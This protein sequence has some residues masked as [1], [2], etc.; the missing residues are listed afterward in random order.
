MKKEVKRR[1]PVNFIYPEFKDTDYHFGL[2]QVIGNVLRPDGDWRPYLP[3]SEEQRRN[4][5]ESSS[6]FVEA[7]QHAIATILEEQYDLFDQN[8]SARFNL[9]FSSATPSGGDPLKAAQSFRDKGL[10]PDTMLPFSDDIKSWQEFNSFKGSDRGLCEKEGKEWRKSWDPKYDVVV[11]KEMDIDTKYTLLKQALKYSPLPF[12]VAQGYDS[13]KPKP[14]GVRDIHLVELVHIDEQNCP[15]VW[16]TYGPNFLKKLAPNYNTDFSM[17][18]TVEKQV[19]TEEISIFMKILNVLLSWT[20]LL[21]KTEPLPK[22]S[23]PLPEP[24]KS[25]LIKWAEGIKMF[26]DYVPPGG[27]YRSGKIATYGSL[28][29]RNKNPGN[30]KALSG[31]F[32][33]FKTYEEGWQAL[34]DYLIRS[35]TGKH[36]AYKPEFSLLQFFKVYAPSDDFNNP[37]IYTAFVAKH[38]G[39]QP[40]TL[41]KNLV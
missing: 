18:W 40:E 13:G 35:A 1:L 14:S 31:A 37:V 10:I 33:S 16:D 12:S 17:R 34:L 20:N 26:E 41:I 25:N 15:Y 38:I 3:P 5:I 22:I 39:V 23:Q 2:G 8:F 7:Q 28:S 36:K 30:L 4:G 32:L 21:P 19:T 6:C 11:R 29:W 24:V 9:I 27:R